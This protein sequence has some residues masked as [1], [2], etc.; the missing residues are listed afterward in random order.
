MRA[1]NK[2]FSDLDVDLWTSLGHHTTRRRPWTRAE[3]QWQPHVERY[4]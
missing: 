2:V 4:G 3:Y 1:Q